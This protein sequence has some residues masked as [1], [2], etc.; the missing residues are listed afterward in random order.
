MK[1]EQAMKTIFAALGLATLLA[2]PPAAAQDPATCDVSEPLDGQRLLRRVSLDLRGYV[3]LY[4]EIQAQRDKTTVDQATIDRMIDS[5]E[6]LGVMRSYHASLVWPNIDQVEIIPQ[7]NILYPFPIGGPDDVIYMSF[8]R[9]VFMRTIG[10]SSLYYPCKNEPARFDAQGRIIAD[11]V[12][13]GSSVIAYQEGY[14]MVEPYWAPGTMIKVCGFDAQSAETAE[15]CPGPTSRYPFIAPY[16]DQI[17]QV[18]DAVQAPFRG[19]T[20]AC[21]GPLSLFAPDCGCGPNLA[22][23]HTAETEATLKKALLDQELRIIDSVIANDRPYHEILTTKNVDMNGPIAHY[24]KYQSRLSF[25]VYADPDPTSPVPD[26]LEFTDTDKW[27]PVTRTGRHAGVLTTPGY[28]LRFQSNRARAHRYYEAFECSSFIPNG[29]L[30]SPFEACSKHED[31]TKRCG[32]NACHQT[33]EPMAAHWGRF[34]E[35]GISPI[36]DARYPQTAGPSCMAPFQ[37]LVQLFRC[38]RFYKTD[39]V[40]EEVPYR[41]QLNAYVFRTPDEIANIVQGPAHLAGASIDGGRFSTCTARKIWTLL[42]RR[43]PTADE[44]KT[45]IPDLVHRYEGANFNLKQ[46]VNDIVTHPAYRRLP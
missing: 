18:A 39:A 12:M 16:C 22:Y 38:L 37:D 1:R 23:C 41:Y 27:L 10:G 31:L 36:D 5:T 32:C 13:M 21:N 28:L 14:V 29:P 3:P 26:G 24:L 8:L 11:P 34:A 45:E 4:D 25:D 2:A 9:A 40:G 44:E 19:A 46:L 35:Y 43:A 33:L 42:M 20:T 17:Q 30:P 6:F 7:Q 15:T